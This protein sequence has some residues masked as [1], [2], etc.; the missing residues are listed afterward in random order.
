MNIGST[1]TRLR[2]ER[3]MT[4]EQLGQA[5]GVSAQAVSKWENGGMPDA[6]LLPAIADR[7]GV[8]VDTLFGREEVPTENMTQTLVRWLVAIPAERRMRALFDLLCVTLRSPYYVDDEALANL[9]KSMQLPMASCWSSDIVNGTE[10]ILW[11]R[12]SSVLEQG[13]QL[14]VPAEDCPLFLLLPEPPE[15]YEASFADNERYRQLFSALAAPGALEILRC[16]YGKKA[17]Y[18]S[19]K[20][21]SRLSGVGLPETE[22]CLRA[23]WKSHLLNKTEVETEVEPMEVYQLTN[24]E[25]FVPF[26]LMARWLSEDFASYICHW[27]GRTSP[28]LRRK[29]TDHE[30]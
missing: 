25:A 22:D 28:I 29:E 6:E 16:L 4:Q 23:M 15:G 27:E 9:V 19:A 18:Y 1:I 20:A 24:T 5:I 14:T 7:L 10:E 30:A 17:R 26:L 11:M 21:I 12:S 13:L 2:K 8:T 3:A